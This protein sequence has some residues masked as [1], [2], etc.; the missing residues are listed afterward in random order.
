MGDRKCKNCGLVN[1][2]DAECCGRCLEPLPKSGGASR[3][4]SVE[5]P[6]LGT[7]NGIGVRLLGWTHREDGTATATTWFTL[8]YLPL[9]PLARYE[10]FT[11]SKE[12]FGPRASVGRVV[13]AVAGHVSLTTNY[14]FTGRL[15][16]S[17]DEV[18][19]TYLF[20]YVGLPLIIF[21]PLA[22]IFAGARLFIDPAD[23][24]TTA[25]LTVGVLML[26]WLGYVLLLLSTL[27]H[28]SRG[29]VE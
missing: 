4:T 5:A 24:S 12:D 20:A 28:R 6:S 1:W 17:G 3:P 19:R 7:F 14:R 2:S 21:A 16:L 18:L 10:L 29:G 25:T 22:A 11:P 8:L 26:A 27:L 9:F 15:P 23:V 13:A